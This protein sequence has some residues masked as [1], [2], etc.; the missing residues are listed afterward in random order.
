MLVVKNSGSWQIFFGHL[1]NDD[2]KLRTFLALHLFP[3]R[4][5]DG[6]MFLIN[7]RLQVIVVVKYLVALAALASLRVIRLFDVLVI[8]SFVYELFS[9]CNA[10]EVK[11]A[12]I[13][14]IVLS[15]RR[16]KDEIVRPHFKVN[17]NLGDI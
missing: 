13:I 4:F 16:S 10:G 3:L 1:I 7:V 11:L 8:L 2:F 14:E 6:V 15:L 12:L 9:A 5:G 17:T